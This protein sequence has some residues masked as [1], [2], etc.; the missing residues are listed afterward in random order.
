MK[1]TMLV[2][3]L[4]ATCVLGS[5][6]AGSLSLAPVFSDHAVLQRDLA[7]PVWGRA[8]PGARI[9]VSINNAGGTVQRMETV[10][11]E[12]GRWMVKTAPTPAGGPYS[13]RVETGGDAVVELDDILFGDV[14]ICSGQSNMEMSYGWGLT[15][16]REEMETNTHPTIRLLNV[17][18][19]TSLLP[20]ESFRASWR[21]CEP[22]AAKRFSAVGYFFG[23]A[24]NEALPEIPIGLIDATWS[25]TYIQTWLSLDS[26]DTVE[27]LRPSVEAWRGQKAVWF[28]DGIEGY[29]RR[30]EEW[31]AGIDPFAVGAVQPSD[32]A[33][34]DS[35]W[36][37]V[38]LPR[39]FEDHISPD[40]DGLVWYRT[41]VELTEEE[42]AQPA[43]LALGAID[44]EDVTYVN[45]VAVG[46]MTAHNVPRRYSVDADVLRPGRNIIS[47]RVLD[48][49]RAG[50]FVS[51]P[52]ALTLELAS[53]SISL[54]CAWTY[55]AHRVSAA[56][57]P[58]NL[59]TPHANSYSVCYNGM[60]APLFPLAAKGAIW[61]QGCSNVGG[62]G[63][64]ERLFPALV[65]DWRA[66]FTA[67]DFPVYL[68]QLAAFRQ[69]H[70]NPIDS[71]WARMRWVM[72]Q[73]GERVPHS[74][75]AVAIDVGDHHDIHPKDK[76]TVGE[77]LAR[78]A[79]SRTYGRTDIVEAGPI[80]LEAEAVDGGR[81]VVRFK[82][83]EGLR[84]VDDG[85]VVGFQLVSADDQAV[86]AEATIQ[87]AHVVVAVPEAVVAKEVRFAWDDYPV[88]NLVNG[89]GLPCG[90]FRLA[91]P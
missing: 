58:Q 80:P 47:V 28:E 42:A 23:T 55:F 63:L 14:W 6:S 18:N 84:T 16:G 44:D 9:S 33:F 5:I 31:F 15:R 30:L 7:A 81:V 87:G 78:L 29:Q 50:G 32:P 22:E 48:T 91:I 8:E 72:M 76:Q 79:L 88:C 27:A 83:A 3:L 66:N 67:T 82:N 40:F 1:R 89:A 77:R 68:V 13:I 10:A 25:G 65:A 24:L 38:E 75:T 70:P 11:D 85:D 64:Y 41:V 90:P 57:R 49:G 86:W 73:L 59:S 34:D 52:E 2:S 69:T 36:Q 46:S 4:I 71:A 45:G 21:V 35:D 51:G 56:G 26:L 61:Y 17:P 12:T 43:S 74:G 20:V 54:A 39:K 53:R 62:E 19:K 60:L 37:Q